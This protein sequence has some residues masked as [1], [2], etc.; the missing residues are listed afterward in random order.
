ME[1]RKEEHYKHF[2]RIPDQPVCDSYVRLGAATSNSLVDQMTN[3][4]AWLETGHGAI[5]PQ[6]LHKVDTRLTIV[7]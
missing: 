6:N 3:W 2:Q 1:G 5:D 7:K 4:E